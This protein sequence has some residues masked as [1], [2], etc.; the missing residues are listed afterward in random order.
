VLSLIFL[1]ITAAASTSAADSKAFATSFVKAVKCSS[2][3]ASTAT[4]D[5]DQ[6][7]P[8]PR[9]V[10]ER[11]SAEANRAIYA[12]V[13]ALPSS[14]RKMARENV[15]A[16]MRR[17]AQR[18]LIA[19]L[20]ANERL[21]A[22]NES[23]YG[24]EAAGARYISCIRLAINFKLEGVYLGETWPAEVAGLAESQ[25]EAYFVRVGQSACP[26]SSSGFAKTLGSAIAAAD[27]SMRPVI[28]RS[29]SVERMN[30][31]AVAP[32]VRMAADFRH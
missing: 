25:R 21:R 7:D 14:D 13:K 19:R 15:E 2:E 31:I 12:M 4:F 27:R 6:I 28:S 23:G 17:E 24:L 26:A 1:I 8:I 20:E 22:G 11:C 9:E 5:R 32:Y 30:R 3:G 16:K 10:Q 18:R 29:W